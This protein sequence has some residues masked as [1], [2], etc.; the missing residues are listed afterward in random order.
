MGRM[1]AYANTGLNIAHVDD[2]AYG[3]LLAYQHGKP[4]KCYILGGDNMSLLQILQAIDTINGTQQNRINIPIGLMLPMA[5]L[6]WKSLH[7]SHTLSHG[8]PWIVFIWQK[9]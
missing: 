4:E 2:I 5:W 3:H 8:L 6:I 9:N 7:L 1:P